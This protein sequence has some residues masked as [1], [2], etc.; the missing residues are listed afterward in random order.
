[1]PPSSTG[2]VGAAP[3]S[4][5]LRRPRL[6][7]WRGGSLPPRPGRGGGGRR[8]GCGAATPSLLARRPKLPAELPR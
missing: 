5:R 2:A 7:P 3:S 1:V 4:T 6:R 8:S